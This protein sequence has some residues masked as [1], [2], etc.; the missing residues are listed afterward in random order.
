MIRR[1][2]CIC[3]V[4]LLFVVV[5][6][7]ASNPME[8]LA[9]I[10][11]VEAVESCFAAPFDSY[12]AWLK[13]RAAQN[14]HFDKV[15]FKEQLPRQE[16]ARYSD[17][18]DCA[19]FE[20]EVDGFTIG[21]FL[22]AP[23]DEAELPVILFNRGGTAE[24]GRM[25]FPGLFLNAFWLAD[26]GYAVIGTQYRGGMGLPPEVGGT[27]EQGGGD[28]RDVQA[29]VPIARTLDVADADRLGMYAASR[30]SVNMFR[31]SLEIEG[32]KTM[33]SVAGLYDLAHS[34]EFRP[35]MERVY[36][37]HIPGFENDREKVL[38]QRSVVEWTDELDLNVPIL[39]LHG[40][41]DERASAM[42]ALRFARQLQERWHPYRLVMFEND[43]H[44]L[45]EHEGEAREIVLDWFDR[46]LR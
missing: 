31:A 1:V 17:R 7:Y 18:L 21:G 37:E 41:Y 46:Y 20:Y 33:V 12:D 35:R 40:T 32:L 3:A 43:D 29:L 8:E 30:G 19:F 9:D 38:A 39:L 22:I 27:D 5:L 36:R 42:G 10:D 23:S 44:F 24:Y 45:S 16:Y 14:H 13:S 15:S 34:L 28:V 26:A 6:A 25:D 4:S 11:S 2:L